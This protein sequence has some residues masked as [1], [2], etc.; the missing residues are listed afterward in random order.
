MKIVCGNIKCGEILNVSE[1]KCPKCGEHTKIVPDMLEDLYDRCCEFTAAAVEKNPRELSISLYPT[2][3]KNYENFM[4]R[5]TMALVVELGEMAQ[6]IP[7]KWWGRGS[8]E[9]SPETREKIAEELID[10]NHFLF[11]GYLLLGMQP[12]E[13]YAAFDKKLKENWKRLKEEKGW[14]E[15]NR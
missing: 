10:I 9:I 15:T 8:W 6:N 2:N 1:Y 13:I 12:S 3:G 5:N 7:Y 4:I 11:V 14:K